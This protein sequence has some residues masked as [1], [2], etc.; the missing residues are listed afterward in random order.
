MALRASALV[1]GILLFSPHI[2][3][4]DVVLLAVALAWLW[5]EANTKGWLPLE[6]PLLLLAWFMP[7]LTF[8]LILGLRWPVGPLYLAMTLVII[9]RRYFWE[10]NYAMPQ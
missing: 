7:L 6:K 3:Y 10:M 5:Q 4:Y 2:W 9:L 1:L 8:L